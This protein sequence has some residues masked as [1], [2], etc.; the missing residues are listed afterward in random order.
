VRALLLLICIVLGGCCCRYQG[1]D[2][3]GVDAFVIESY[4]IREGKRAIMELVG[5]PM[6][7]LDPATLEE[8]RDV[9]DDGDVLALAIFHPTRSDLASAVMALDQEMGFPV[10]EGCVSLPLLDP[11]RIEGLTL[12]EAKQRLQGAYD[13]QVGGTEVFVNYKSR[14]RAKVELMGEVQVASLP[15]NGRMRLFEVLG[16]ARTPA[17]AN[18]FASY[19]LRDGVHLPVDLNRLVNE[20]DMSQNIVMRPHD[21][22]FI[23]NHNKATVMVTG[24][25]NMPGPVDVPQGM[26][27]LRDAIVS[28]GGIPFTGN[29]QC[30]QVIRGNVPDPRIFL[31]KWNTIVH[32]PNH[33]LLLMPGDT[34]YVSAKPITEWNRFIDQLLPS[35]G[36]VQGGATTIRTVAIP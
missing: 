12:D 30:I 15:V 10:V 8:Y 11:I 36:G 22:V 24:E 17:N 32:L 20:G 1:Y 28:A 13:R 21:K 18:W 26:L 3:C 33:S 5:Q 6:A 27:S 16:Q 29:K 7:P 34:V 2:T 25:V 23:A 9:V 35:I 14:P 19:V 31:L 4:K